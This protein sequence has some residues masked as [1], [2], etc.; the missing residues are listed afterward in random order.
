MKILQIANKAFFPP[1]GGNLAILNLS[2]GFIEN[3]HQV[4][5][6]NMETYKHKNTP[7]F[8]SNTNNIS[9]E[10]IAV[11][12]RL[13]LIS[14]LKNLLFSKQAYI[15]NR[16]ISDEFK[17]A[18]IQKEKKKKYDFILL[19]NL[20]CLQ[21][22]HFIKNYFSGVIAYRSHNIECLIWR[23]NQQYE[24]NFFKKKY[25]G[26]LANRLEQLE[27]KLLNTYDYIFPISTIDANTYIAY[28]NKKPLL[29][30]PFG[31]EIK[32]IES[33]QKSDSKFLNYLG[34]L[35]WIPNQ[36]GLIWFI[37]NCLPSIQQEF[38]NITLR[39]AGRNAPD[40]F[41]KK[42]QNPS[43]E[44]LGEIENASD[45]YSLSGVFIVPLFAG[46]GMRVKIIEAMANK[47]AVITTNIGAEGINCENQKN[48]ILCNT[49]DEYIRAIKNLFR[50]PEKQ[51]KIE[52][53][54]FDFVKKNYDFNNIA[55]QLITFIQSN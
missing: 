44:Y 43:I 50:N 41:V 32:P 4:D 31:M 10:G 26:I 28:G 20:Y 35:D 17:T 11:N 9:I 18:I 40:W 46:S 38:P 33:K 6:L 48:I 3:N 7:D 54:A 36:Q 55:K 37:E 14:A 29:T 21:Y 16:F 27:K 49:P 13:K 24:N 34:A 8:L 51:Y 53:N 30:I 25:Y 52:E 47:K 1:D 22:I 5:I 12:T 15:A 19:E 23:R 42:L 39:I 2:K 45:F